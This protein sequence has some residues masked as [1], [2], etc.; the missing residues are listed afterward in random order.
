MSTVLPVV[1]HDPFVWALSF[2]L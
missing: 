2:R 1:S